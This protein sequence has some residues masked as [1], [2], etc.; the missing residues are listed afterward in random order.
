MSWNLCLV[1]ITDFQSCIPGTFDTVTSLRKGFHRERAVAG[2]GP[3]GL[4][5]WCNRYKHMY[6]WH[7]TDPWSE[8]PGEPAWRETLWPSNART[9]QT[10]WWV[11]SWVLPSTS[12]HRLPCRTGSSCWACHGLFPLTTSAQWENKHKYYWCSM[13]K[14]AEILL[15]SMQFRLGQIRR[16]NNRNNIPWLCIPLLGLIKVQKLSSLGHG[17]TTWH[18]HEQNAND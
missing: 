13:R 14:R 3:S 6:S 4:N 16:L 1:F 7:T 18:P 15:T 11:C 12:S 10:V 2:L 5:V 9:R 17:M 8:V